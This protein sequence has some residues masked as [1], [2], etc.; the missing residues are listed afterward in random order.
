MYF[1][2]PEPLTAQP[3]LYSE[4]IG[5]LGILFPLVKSLNIAEIIDRV[6]P[7]QAQYSHG[8]VLSALLLARLQSP[9]A[10]VNVSAWARNHAIECLL[11]IPPE[12]L[13]DDRLG[14]ALDAFHEHRYT[15]IA[16]ITAEVLR[17][18]N[19]SLEAAHFDT[20]HL[21]FYGSYDTSEP[22]PQST[23]EKML[24]I[25]P[26]NDFL[27]DIKMS[28]AHI[29][30]GYLTKYRML[31]FGAT[32]FVDDFGPIP[33]ACHAVDGNR[34]G[35]TAIHQQYEILRDSLQLPEGFLLVS[36]RGTCS[37]EHLARLLDHGHF[38]LCACPWKDYRQYFDLHYEQLQWTVPSYM[39]MEQDRRRKID[40]PL[41][42]ESYRIAE[43]SHTFKHFRTNETIPARLIFV[44]STANEKQAKLRRERNLAKIRAGLAEF[45]EKLQR[46]HASTKPKSIAKRIYKLLENKDAAAYVDWEIVPLTQAEQDALPTPPRG[47]CKQ[48]HRLEYTVNEEAAIAD[49]KYDGIYVLIT[50]APPSQSADELFAEYKRQTYVE[51]GHHELKTPLAVTPVFLKTPERVESLLSL[52]FIALQVYMTLERKY[53]QSV[54]DMNVSAREKRTTAETILREFDRCLLVIEWHP[55]GK[56]MKGMLMSRQQHQILRQVSLDAADEIVRRI[57]SPPPV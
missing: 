48:T 1:A 19:V 55:Y 15:I 24:D 10:L 8:T 57:L 49:K 52:L 41:S 13:N 16:D 35:H 50:T 27:N 42:R 22:R 39:S 14:R 21:E 32:S 40:S 29:S 45:A 44:H 56:V 4:N 43:V 37:V 31:Q 30:H 28:A 25:D 6:I 12:K 3:S 26:N 34:T 18:T 5:S 38:A 36:D 51:R 2:A 54:A 47:Y 33:I 7:T 20:T 23:L 11:N 9:T 17:Q 46:A 53:R